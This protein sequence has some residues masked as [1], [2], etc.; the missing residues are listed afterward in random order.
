[1]KNDQQSRLP[2]ADIV[3]TFLDHA[4]HRPDKVFCRLN[5]AGRV[6][7][8][9]YGEL[10]QAAARFAGFL[11]RHAI[12]RTGEVVVIILPHGVELLWSFLGV[13]WR[14]AVPTF[15]PFPSA[16]QD[17]EYYW[18]SHAELFR[19]IGARTLV[20]SVTY[21]EEIERY[22][23]INTVYIEEIAARIHECEPLSLASAAPDSTAFLQHSSGTT[24]LK[25]GVMLS[26][27]SV[28]TQVAA[29]AQELGF[30]EPHIVASWL[31]LYHD[32]GLIACFMMPLLIGATVA[33]LDPF[34]WVARPWSILDVIENERA[35]FTW[36]P[37]F[38]FRH[39]VRTAPRQRTWDLSSLV[40][41]INCSEPCKPTEFE[42]FNDRFG[43]SGVTA[44]SLQV[45]Y[46]M[47]ENVFA[48]AQTSLESPPR[49]LSADADRMDRDGAVVPSV[50]E[51][52]TR[53]LVSCGR[54]L[55]ETDIR[56]LSSDGMP[57][58]DRWVG[59]IVIRSP[60]LFSGYNQLPELTA[61]KLVEGWYY[62][63]DLGFLDA[64]ELFVTG[65]VDDLIIVYGRNYYAHEIEEAANLVDGVAP[66]RIVA[67]GVDSAVTGTTEVIILAELLDDAEPADIRRG[68]KATVLDRLGLT[69]QAVEFLPRGQLAKSTAGKISRDR[70]RANY[71]NVRGEMSRA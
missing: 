47:A 23:D 3:Y 8:V 67:F 54:P 36:M 21:R 62:T 9:A 7:P 41:L 24:G 48:V 49:L 35:N 70:N 45:C 34:E 68:M 39:I 20:S 42:A 30:C 18:D 50:A 64:G 29:Y 44:R 31:P 60:S 6:I 22:L 27:N 14:R 46:A 66:G 69:V 52:K 65:R 1:M 38:A 40:A 32:M 11:D 4:D 12:V 51:R 25:K 55:P 2:D 13:M 26:H 56:I 59:E 71:L 58:P 63:G 61:R 5:K 15:M 37:N 16:K 53:R 17:P 28:M 10:A 57:L 43:G 19:K 33:M